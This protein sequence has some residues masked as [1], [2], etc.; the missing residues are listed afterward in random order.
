MPPKR[1]ARRAGREPNRLHRTTERLEDLIAWSLG[2]LLVVAGW[3]A[4]QT[5]TSV[6]DSAI[7]RARVQAQDRTPVTAV[8]IQDTYPVAIANESG[9]V[10]VPVRWTGRD[11]VEHTDQMVVQGIHAAG[12]PLPAWADRSGHLVPAP[13]TPGVA[14]AGAVEIGVVVGALGA[15]VVALIGFAAFRWTARRYARA[16]EQEWARVG[17]EW[18]GRTRS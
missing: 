2:L 18:S 14:T 16:W 6:H 5:G 3:A 10:N 17:P 13:I 12:D 1:P 9:V 8:L 4:L 7:E 11:G 15:G